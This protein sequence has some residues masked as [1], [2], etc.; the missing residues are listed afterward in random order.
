MTGKTEKQLQQLI[1]AY[2][3]G[4]ASSTSTLLPITSTPSQHRN[5]NEHRNVV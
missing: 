1:D 2:N 4:N 5:S 3:Q